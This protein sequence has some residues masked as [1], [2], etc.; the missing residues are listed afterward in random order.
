M[1]HSYSLCTP[2]TLASSANYV[3]LQLTAHNCPVPL[4]FV[5]ADEEEACKIV[6]CFLRLLGDKQVSD[7]N[8]GYY[9]VLVC[10]ALTLYNRTIV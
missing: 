4:K 6:N 3:N 9:D 1:L 5:H 10:I 8:E 7:R 2:S